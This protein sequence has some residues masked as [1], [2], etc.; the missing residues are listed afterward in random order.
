MSDKPSLS[1]DVVDGD[2]EDD[3]ERAVS[4]RRLSQGGKSLPEQLEAIEAYAE[5]HGLELVENFSDGQH[6]SG[7]TEDREAYQA[8]LERLEA[9]DVGHV[10]ARDRS[11]FARDARDRLRLW[12][13]LDDLDVTIHLA[14]TG[15]TVDLEDPYA[16]TRESAQADADDV[17]K[18][19]EAERGKAEAERRER[20]GLPNGRPPYGLAYS[21]DKTELVAG[22]SGEIEAA[23]RAI[24][25]RDEG[26]TLRE[27]SDET[28]INR[29][30]ARRIADRR[31]L[32]ERVS[33]PRTAPKG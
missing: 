20:E 8:L 26:K 29:E 18:R 17:E 21:A 30:T 10:V 7:Y 12:L 32:Y 15:E 25:L 19:K 2:Q 13:D 24:E 27:I 9:G 33:E 31:E 28:G 23:L 16:L 5:E 11:R 1:A 6:A 4:Y 3:V 22:A 14:E